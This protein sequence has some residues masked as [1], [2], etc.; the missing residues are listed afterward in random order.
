MLSKNVVF[1][2][3]LYIHPSK[4][5]YGSDHCTVFW[6]DEDRDKFFCQNVRNKVRNGVYEARGLRD[7]LISYIHHPKSAD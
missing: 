3:W 1:A 7:S 2:W 4:R 5:V 6:Y